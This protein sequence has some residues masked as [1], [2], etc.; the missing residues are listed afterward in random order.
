VR[1][2]EEGGSQLGRGPGR[3]ERK[4]AGWIW[5]ER[6]RGE[7][8]GKELPFSFSNTFFNRISFSLNK[9]LSKRHFVFLTI[10]TINAPACMQ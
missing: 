10:I 7:G 9:F 2:G 8:G 3:G 5:A 1:E 6:P 4:G